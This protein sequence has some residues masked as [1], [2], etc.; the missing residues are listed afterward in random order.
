MK[1]SL[2]V[3]AILGSFAGAASAQTSV[4][5][6]GLLDAGINY[7]GGGN[8]ATLAGGNK[9]SLQ[10]GISQAS[11][12]GFKGTEDLGGNLKAIFQ[13]EMG[14]QIDTGAS[15][16]TGSLFNRASWIGLTGD[17]GTVTAG[18]QFTPLY[19][20]LK[21]ID[22]FELG[23]AG[24]AHNLMNVGGANFSSSNPGGNDVLNGGGS[25]WQNNSLRYATQNY[26]G[27]S[28]EV[29][30]GFGEQA[31]NHSGASEIG[32]AL[33]Y[34]NGPFALLIAYDGVNSVTNDHTFKTTLLGGS[35]NWGAF[36]LPV[37]TSLGYAIN[38][39]TNVD[40]IAGVD[41]K[42]FVFGIRMPVGPHEILGSYIHKDDRSA[43]SHDASQFA[44]GYTYTLSKRTSFYS[45]IAMIRN[46]NGAEYTVGNASNMGFGRKAFDFGIRHS[47]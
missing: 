1:K 17:F 32:V 5:A 45:S 23:F 8:A 41:S 33:N 3:I 29:N 39:G 46:K 30:Y 24:N 21:T 43:L 34:G 2:L 31:G 22:P 47:F 10:S 35:V 19:N 38:K 4:T 42:D 26:N 14:M 9:V 15:T 25:S 16:E 13:L 11:R 12:I 44:L 37:K 40:S 36:G 6:Y 27:F 20:S 7:E 18:R 28:A